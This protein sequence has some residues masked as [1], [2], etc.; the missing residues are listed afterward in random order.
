MKNAG[1]KTP[2][3]AVTGAAHDEMQCLYDAGVVAVSLR[4]RCFPCIFLSKLG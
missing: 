2:V 4:N 1:I 3:V